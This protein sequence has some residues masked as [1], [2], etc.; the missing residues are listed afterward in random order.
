MKF[1]FIAAS[2]ISSLVAF[3]AHAFSTFNIQY[4][5]GKT[6]TYYRRIKI[7]HWKMFTAFN[8]LFL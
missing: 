5:E 8:R 6:S 4:P 1:R 3:N 7:F 2:L